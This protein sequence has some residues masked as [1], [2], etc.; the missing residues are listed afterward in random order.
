MSRPIQEP[1]SALSRIIES[2]PVVVL[3]PPESTLESPIFDDTKQAAAEP[4][5]L[6]Q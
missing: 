1:T 2:A 5:V 6:E 3:E 4:D